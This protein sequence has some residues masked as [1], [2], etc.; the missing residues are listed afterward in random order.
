MDSEKYFQAWQSHFASQGMTEEKEEL[1]KTKKIVDAL[2]DKVKI[3]WNPEE[4]EVKEVERNLFLKPLI[5]LS[6]E[7]FGFIAFGV[8]LNPT[9]IRLAARPTKSINSRK[10]ASR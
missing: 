6:L 7:N 9:C 2:F 10:G 1:E 8:T 4:K 3:T 5:G